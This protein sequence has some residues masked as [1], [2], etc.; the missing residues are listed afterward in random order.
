[1][2]RDD[3]SSSNPASFLNHCKE[4]K[5]IHS[6]NVDE[7]SNPDDRNESLERSWLKTVLKN[8]LK[9]QTDL[10]RSDRVDKDT[11]VRYDGLSLVD[12]VQA[13]IVDDS[14]SVRTAVDIQD[15]SESKE[16][17]SVEQTTNN[18]SESQDIALEQVNDSSSTSWLSKVRQRKLIYAALPV[19]DET[20]IS[21]NPEERSAHPFVDIVS[22][23]HERTSLIN[24]DISSE[25]DSFE[26]ATDRDT[27][28]TE[29]VKSSSIS[30][31]RR[32][33]A[34]KPSPVVELTT[35]DHARISPSSY[36]I[37]TVHATQAFSPECNSLIYSNICFSQ[38]WLLIAIACH[39]GQ[40]TVLL[41]IGYS[42]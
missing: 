8:K 2:S 18:D 37:P 15:S 6:D 12:D 10:D 1:M 14:E 31:I 26:A 33:I 39:V 24:L 19:N 4:K 23:P 9:T 36:N 20:S 38:E 16:A 34:T 42:S 13:V 41:S 40:F 3:V 17:I 21:I 28:S 25:L 5:L 29:E 32:N 11:D 27:H 7:I 35:L 22:T 30:T